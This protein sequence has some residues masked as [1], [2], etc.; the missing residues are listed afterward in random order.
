MEVFLFLAEGFEETEAVT[1]IDILYRGGL[2][3]TTVSVTGAK[4][5]TGTHRIPVVADKLFEE[6][7]FSNGAMLIL[8]GGMPGASNLNAHEELKSL[9][10]YYHNERKRI[11]AICA[12]PLVLGGLGILQDKQATVYPGYEDTLL[13]ARLVN[14]AVVKDGNIITGKGPGFVFDF[15]LVI[16][17]ELQGQKRAN[18]VASGMLLA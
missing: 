7:D 9:L 15:G 6:T 3:V 1:T 2:K 13:G 4:V 12:A 17:A 10:M 11:A 18:K 5:V 16:V 8:P 14:A